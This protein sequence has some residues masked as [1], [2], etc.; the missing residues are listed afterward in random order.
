[1][2]KLFHY[3]RHSPNILCFIEIFLADISETLFAKLTVGDEKFHFN[4]LESIYWA[5]MP[6][7]RHRF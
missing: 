4:L 6:Q 5:S 3:T 7:I 1:M 2:L